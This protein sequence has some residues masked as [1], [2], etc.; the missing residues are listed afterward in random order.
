MS[1]VS[2]KLEALATLHQRN[3]LHLLEW[4][5]ERASIREFDG[6]LSRAEAER[7]A[8]EDVANELEGKCSR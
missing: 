6:G 8:L 2:A 1:S 7:L 5:L 4:F 3:P